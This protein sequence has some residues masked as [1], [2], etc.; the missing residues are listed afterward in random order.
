MVYICMMVRSFALLEDQ[1]LF[2]AFDAPRLAESLTSDDPVVQARTNPNLTPF[3]HPFL[4]NQGYQ[5][6]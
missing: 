4:K 2:E 3:L 1:V 5:D 6:C